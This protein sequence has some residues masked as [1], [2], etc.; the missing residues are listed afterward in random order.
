MDAALGCQ[1][2]ALDNGAIA[3]KA[4]DVADRRW[5]REPWIDREKGWLDE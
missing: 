4:F 3:A 5:Q 1:P 2:E